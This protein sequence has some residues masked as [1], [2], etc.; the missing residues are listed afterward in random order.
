MRGRDYDVTVV[1][2]GPVGLSLA[3]GLARAD[4]SVLVLE[5]A[6]GVSEHSRAPLVWPR[7]LE[8]FAELDVIDRFQEEGIVLSRI[9]LWDADRERTLLDLPLDDL[10]AATDFPQ[11]LICPQ[12][13]T[14]RL[15]CE[16]VQDQPSA[17]VL[18][19]AEVL[20]VS[21]VDGGVQV[22]YQR[23]GTTHTTT[24]AFAAG[25]DGARSRVRE[26]LGASCEGLTYQMRPLWRTSC[27]IRTATSASRV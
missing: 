8:I 26:A 3:L 11:L 2:A 27:S 6:P 16:A 1:G 9:Q 7:P 21:E 4:R 5:K 20:D 15:L 10:Q 12:L 13:Q 18:F 23:E 14:E 19:S 24:S 17:D 22:S 25:C